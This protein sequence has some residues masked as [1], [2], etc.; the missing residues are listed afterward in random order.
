MTKENIKAGFSGA[1]LVPHCP[2]AVLSKLDIQLRTPTPNGPPNVDPWTSQTPR[3]PTEALSQTELVR[4]SIISHQ[5]SSPT[6]IFEAAS[7]LAKGTEVLAH[8]VTLL[9]AE[10]H[11]LR[12]ANRALSKRRRAKKTRIRQGGALTIGEG[13][14]LLAQKEGN[15]Q[16]AINS[17]ASASTMRCCSKCKKAGHNART[18]GN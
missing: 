3:N 6:R 17:Q 10:V 11:T 1:G 5:G 9:M 12:E 15:T 14:D 7:S 18:C 8:T 16:T 13:Q 2:Q 4:N